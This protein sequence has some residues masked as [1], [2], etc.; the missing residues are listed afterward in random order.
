[1]RE[2]SK[3]KINQQNLSWAQ[4]KHLQIQNWKE[5]DVWFLLKLSVLQV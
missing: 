4:L 1:M 2:P 5:P 3:G